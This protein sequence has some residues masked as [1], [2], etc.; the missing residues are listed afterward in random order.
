VWEEILTRESMMEE[1]KSYG[2][3]EWNWG[4]VDEVKRKSRV[5]DY[6]HCNEK[7]R[8]DEEQQQQTV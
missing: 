3:A 5:P 2:V 6:L 7:T 8:V 1:R 4:R